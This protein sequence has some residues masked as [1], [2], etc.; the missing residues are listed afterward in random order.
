MLQRSPTI[1]SLVAQSRPPCRRQAVLDERLDNASPQALHYVMSSIVLPLATY[2]WR[3]EN[4]VE[5]WAGTDRHRHRSSPG[6]SD[7]GEHIGV[8]DRGSFEGVSVEDHQLPQAKVDAPGLCE[9][10]YSRP[11]SYK[12]GDGDFPL[13]GS[14]DP[15]LPSGHGHDSGDRCAEGGFVTSDASCCPSSSRGRAR[16]SCE[17]GHYDGD[18]RGQAV[19]AKPPGNSRPIMGSSTWSSSSLYSPSSLP[20]SPLKTVGVASTRA[21]ANES[22]SPLLRRPPRQPKRCVSGG[23]GTT[24]GG[25]VLGTAPSPSPS[26]LAASQEEDGFEM[27]EAPDTLQTDSFTVA[28]SPRCHD[29]GRAMGVGQGPA[30]PCSETSEGREGNRT[31]HR[32]PV[33]RYGK[34]GEAQFGGSEGQPARAGRVAAIQVTSPALLALLLMSKSFLKHLASLRRAAEFGVA[35]QQV[36]TKTIS[37]NNRYGVS[38]VRAVCPPQSAEVVGTARC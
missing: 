26:S 1:H 10:Y 14:A 23:D 34:L 11:P 12:Q 2:I 25:D 33:R 13:T 22:P 8:F 9:Q 37:Q 31:V 29:G 17:G 3:R 7:K 6:V 30:A 28:K 5:G 32:L 4:L 38:S 18:K 19:M 21:L 35:W 36:R 15:R 27:V 16:R 24:Q 20:L